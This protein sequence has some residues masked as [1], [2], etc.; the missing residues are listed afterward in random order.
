MDEF[1]FTISLHGGYGDEHLDLFLDIDGISRL[2]TFGAQVSYWENLCQGG[3][4]TFRRK[5][6]HRRIYLEFEGEIDG[7]GWIRILTHGIAL[8]ESKLKNIK[9]SEEVQAS[10]KDGK[11]L[12]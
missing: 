12:L 8:V 4:V 10:L 2:I 11:L 6:D 7:K 5:E 9:G 1:P 3:T